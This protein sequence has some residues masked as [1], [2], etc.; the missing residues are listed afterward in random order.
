M[1]PYLGPLMVPLFR[2]TEG[3]S[4]DSEEVRGGLVIMRVVASQVQA[5]ASGRN[6]TACNRSQGQGQTPDGGP[7]QH[8]DSQ[9]VGPAM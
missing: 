8:I 1:K 6:L 7:L 4:A 5:A 3:G 9:E 2:I